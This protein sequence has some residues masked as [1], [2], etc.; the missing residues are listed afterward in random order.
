M[1]F[2]SL[3][4][5]LRHS[6]KVKPE[7]PSPVPLPTDSARAATIPLDRPLTEEERSIAEWL[8][9]NAI[10]PALDY[11]P[12]LAIAQVKGQCS[13]GC[14]TVDLCLPD[15]TPRA[16]P[17]DSPIGDAVGEVNGDMV[18]VMLMQREGHLTCLE[19]YD[20]SDIARPYGLPDVRSLR[21]F[22]VKSK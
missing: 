10:P 9:V 2:S 19:V 8:L 21:P 22:E 6:F 5:Q 11:L 15:S 3:L 1:D 14:P 16:Q 12:Q 17:R 13:C 18:G 4:S 7:D 20:L